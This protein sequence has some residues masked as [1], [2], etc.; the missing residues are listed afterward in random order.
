MSTS[1][2]P[3]VL[4]GPTPS[5]AA[6]RSQRFHEQLAQ[7]PASVFNFDPRIAEGYY[8][9]RYFVRTARTLAHAGLDPIVRMQ[10]FAKKA[11]VL[12]GMYQAVRLLETQLA[13]NPRTLQRYTLRDFRIETLMDGDEIAPHEPVLHILGP[14]VAF[15]HLETI[16]LGSMARRTLVASNVR[17]VV[18]AAA[19]KPVI[20][21]GARHDEWLVQTPDGYAAKLGGISSVS[22]DANGAWWGAEGVG[23]MPHSMIATM[24]GDVVR[25]TKAFTRMCREE[26]PD[27]SIVSLVDYDNDVVTDSLNVAR[28]MQAEFGPGML[29]GVRVDTGEANID[30]AL[31]GRAAEFPGDKLTGVCPPLIRELRHAF[32]AQGFA[33]VKIGVSGGFTPTKM[34]RFVEAG[35]P[36]DFFGVGSSLLGHNNGD[37]D[38]LVN[39]FDFTADIT[40]LDGLPESK[41]GRGR[42][43]NARFVSV[44]INRVLKGVK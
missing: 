26:E 20:L 42:R 33:D 12:G 22:S 31:Q 28:A 6:A 14:Y 11:G 43:D 36:V 3:P 2:R 30:R 39:G 5:E 17:R 18:D 16:Y 40:E 10:V 37:A 34:R 32:D 27:V 21:M 7:F 1:L 15:A 19:G 29:W 4:S 35:V 25:A 13:L 41:V 23:T 9:D 8:S 24:G 44:D 38:G